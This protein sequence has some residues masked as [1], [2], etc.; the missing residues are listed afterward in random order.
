MGSNPT[1]HQLAS[2]SRVLFVVA[3]GWAFFG[4]F[5][6]PLQDNTLAFVLSL[7]MGGWTLALAVYARRRAT[8]APSGE[9]P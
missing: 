8:R 2:A 4:V 3:P 6:G 1:N 5:L 9:V 7:A